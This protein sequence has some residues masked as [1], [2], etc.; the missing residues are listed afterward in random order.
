MTC[1]VSDLIF[2]SCYI[3]YFVNLLRETQTGSSVLNPF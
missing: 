2:F 1:I 3:N